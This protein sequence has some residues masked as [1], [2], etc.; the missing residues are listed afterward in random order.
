MSI[1]ATLLAV[2]VLGCCLVSIVSAGCDACS[3]APPGGWGP[4]DHSK[5]PYWGMSL[6]EIMNA[7][8]S[9]VDKSNTT[10]GSD[11][12]PPPPI[13]IPLSN[14]GKFASLFDCKSKFGDSQSIFSKNASILKPDISAIVIPDLNVKSNLINK[15]LFF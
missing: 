7:A 14:S 6:D 4:P 12:W 1:R 8:R 2:I 9:S 10:S 13:T 11:Y 5:D 15:Q 3:A